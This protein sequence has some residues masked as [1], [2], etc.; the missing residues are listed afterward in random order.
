VRS[1]GGTARVWRLLRLG[2]GVASSQS[3][4]SAGP[5]RKPMKRGTV[6][7]HM[8]AVGFGSTAGHAAGS[9]ERQRDAVNPGTAL[10][11]AR[12]G[13]RPFRLGCW[14]AP[15]PTVWRCTSLRRISIS[16]VSARG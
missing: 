6:R 9:G 1:E 3:G 13:A 16:P 11:G 12:S 10:F 2:Q 4:Q 14:A 7:A 15:A 5:Q 8:V